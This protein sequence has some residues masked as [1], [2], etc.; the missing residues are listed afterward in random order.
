MVRRPAGD[1]RRDEHGAAL[2]LAVGHACSSFVEEPHAAICSDQRV[3]TLNLVAA[4]HGA[5]RAAA[6]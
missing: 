2:P 3:E 1:E 5:V 4:E 6:G